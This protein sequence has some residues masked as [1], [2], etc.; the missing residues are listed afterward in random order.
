MK[1]LP[2]NLQGY[3]RQFIGDMGQYLSLTTFVQAS[4]Q[5]SDHIYRTWVF[6]VM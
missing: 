2:G 5:Y 6:N 3:I 4:F 1:L